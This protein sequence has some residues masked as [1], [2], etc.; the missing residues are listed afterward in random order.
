[1]RY[2]VVYSVPNSLKRQICIDLLNNNISVSC[3]ISE[4]I[5]N[6][7]LAMTFPFPK[8]SF[9]IILNLFPVYVVLFGKMIFLIDPGF[10]FLLETFCLFM[11]NSKVV[12]VH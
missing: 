2:S 9:R 8:M 3:F 11:L 5:E 4:Y 10:G 7:W 6:N 12:L 1:M